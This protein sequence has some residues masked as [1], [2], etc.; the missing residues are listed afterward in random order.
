MRD[1]L[2]LWDQA[3][4]DLDTEDFRDSPSTGENMARV[5]WPRLDARLDGLLARLRLFETEN[6]RFTLRL[7]RV[8]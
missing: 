5:L 4:L 8:T 3:H 6:N 1:A 2:D 7:G